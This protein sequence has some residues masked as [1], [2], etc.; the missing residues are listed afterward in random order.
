VK[1]H[2][3]DG[4]EAFAVVVKITETGGD[5]L[6]GVEKDLG[7]KIHDDSVDTNDLSEP[8]DIKLEP[9]LHGWCIETS[10]GSGGPV[11]LFK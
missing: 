10:S 4:D 8:V 1:H 5:T 3:F 11:G 6:G 2:H 7:F 9:D